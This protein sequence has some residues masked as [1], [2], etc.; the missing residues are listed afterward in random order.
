M[1][2]SVNT[3]LPYQ[4]RVLQ[5]A[6]QHSV[7]VVEKSRRIG[8][9]WSLGGAA[10][11]TA[12]ARRDA[13]GMDVLYIGTSRDMAREF[14]DVAA[15]WG[16]GVDA[17]IA[18][19][20]E[21]LWQGN[22]ES[23]QAFRLKFKSGFE[24]LALSSRPRSLRGRQGFVIIDEAAWHDDLPGLMKAAVAML[25]W[26][27]R[28]CVVS[29]HNG[30][31]NP[32]NLLV[33]DCRSGDKKHEVIRITFSDAIRDGLAERIAHQKGVPYSAGFSVD[34]EAGIRAEYG[35]DSGEELDAIPAAGRGAFLNAAL[36]EARMDRS[37]PVC[38]WA[39]D[40]DL[41]DWIKDHLSPI[42]EGCDPLLLTYV[43]MDV[44]RT[45][46]P[47]AIYIL[48]T[49]RTLRRLG[50]GLIELRRLPFSVQEKIA[51]FLI[52]SLPRLILF[53]I[54]A[55]GIGAGLAERLN[56]NWGSLV[57][58]TKLSREWYRIAMPPLRAAF[59]DGSITIPS[60]LDLRLDLR[61]IRE[62]G[63]IAKIGGEAY[64]GS[65]GQPRHGDAAMALALAYQASR[66]QDSAYAYDAWHDPNPDE[67]DIPDPVWAGARGTF[68]K[69]GLAL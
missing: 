24:V 69:R 60:F 61:A 35:A 29:T 28:V 19:Y 46:H 41:K 38:C 36:I 12:A 26:G 45:G 40:G 30:V 2:P 52:T 5:A 56:Q 62:E 7:L 6:Q 10:V 68:Y 66:E 3:L 50:R 37:I 33:Q 53:S 27:G 59:E 17:A 55:G 57:R 47:S 63:G 25:V 13:G 31:D 64:K 8:I 67:E 1:K 48:Q 4:R 14:I 58:E 54:D 23:I 51:D 18:E 34:F 42:I 22:G 39:G 9:T 32:F 49:D 16:E 44:G 65:D 43:G 11:L 20:G 21:T 15:Q